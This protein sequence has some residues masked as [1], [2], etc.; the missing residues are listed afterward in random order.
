MFALRLKQHFGGL[1]MIPHENGSLN[2]GIIRIYMN[3]QFESF[4]LQI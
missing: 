2:H 3:F 4:F 1:G